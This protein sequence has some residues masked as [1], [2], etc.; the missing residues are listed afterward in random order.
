MKRDPQTKCTALSWSER[1]VSFALLFQSAALLDQE[2]LG[3]GEITFGLIVYHDGEM[4]GLPR[5]NDMF[6]LLT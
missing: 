3:S 2:K 4:H 5:F 1:A 6:A